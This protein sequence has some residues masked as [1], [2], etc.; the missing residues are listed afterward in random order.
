MSL[1]RAPSFA[2]LPFGCLAFD[3][4]VGGCGRTIVLID[5]TAR[6]IKPEDGRICPDPPR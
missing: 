3:Q 5:P 1:K 4:T 2:A 6:R